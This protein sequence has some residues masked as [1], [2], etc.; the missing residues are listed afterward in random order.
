MNASSPLVRIVLSLLTFSTFCCDILAQNRRAP[1]GGQLGVVVD[2]RLSCL[3]EAPDLSAKL[4]QRIRRGRL[5]AI[6]AFKRSDDGV[7]F[8]RVKVTRRTSGWLQREAVVVPSQKREDERLWRLIESSEQF[9]RIARA[10]IFLDMFPR[11]PLRPAVLL[12][13]GDAAAAAATGLSRD[14]VRRLDNDE[15]IAAAAP[16]F[17]YFLNYNGLDRYNRQ[18]IRFG[19]DPFRK[20]FYYTGAAWRE[21]LR[22]YPQSPE[23]AEA[24][25]RLSR[26]AVGKGTSG[27]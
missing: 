8:F 22:R 15:M 18:G 13:Y 12:L 4:L 21:I 24:R 27:P 9:D 14:A 6:R 26:T 7:V 25:Q 2:D 5:V 10:R 11:S 1:S 17:S 16:E 20:Q 23:A 3:R 19:F